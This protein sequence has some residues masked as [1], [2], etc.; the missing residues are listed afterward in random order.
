MQVVKRWVLLQNTLPIIVSQCVSSL[1]G[2]VARLNL[3]PH[4]CVFIP[5]RA[6]RQHRVSL[7]P[8]ERPGC[9][10]LKNRLTL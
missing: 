4:V 5:Q 2:S 8:S 7:F 1:N 6:A 9:A 10:R 3:S